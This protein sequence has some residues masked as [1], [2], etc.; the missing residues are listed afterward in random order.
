MKGWD[1]VVEGFRFPELE[2]C[3]TTE[4]QRRHHQACDVPEGVFGDRADP[5][6]LGQDTARAAVKAGLPLDGRIHL[7]CVIRQRRPVALDERLRLEGRVLP[8]GPSPRGRLLNAA[9]TFRDAAGA[10]PLEMEMHYLLPGPATGE[11]GPREAEP[12]PAAFTPIAEMALTPEKVMAYS[13]E[14][15]NLIHFDADFAKAAGFRAP[16]AQGQMQV[17]AAIGALW[18]DL[19]DDFTLESRFLRPL[20]WDDRAS[21]EATADRRRLRFVAQDGRIAGTAELR[22]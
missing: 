13:A 18:A 8:F 19:P 1:A 5:S 3:V 7:R 17:T 9:F 2:A 14:A 6:I 16:L 20:H 12:A 21:I 22:S 15:G 10:A 11:R 4:R